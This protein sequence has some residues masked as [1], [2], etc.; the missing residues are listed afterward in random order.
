MLQSIVCVRN[1]DCADQISEPEAPLTMGRYGGTYQHSTSAMIGIPKSPN[2]S[3][4]ASC[5]ERSA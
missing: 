1:I 4:T 3:K 5:W 2:A